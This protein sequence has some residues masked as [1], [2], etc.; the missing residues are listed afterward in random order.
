MANSMIP[1]FTRKSLVEWAGEQVV[2][3]AERMVERGLVLSAEYDPPVVRGTVLANNQELTTSLKLHHDGTVE[4]L[5][6]CYANRERGIVCSHVIAIASMLVRRRTDPM[7]EAKYQEEQRRAKRLASIP[8]TEYLQRVPMFTAGACPASVKLTLPADWMRQ[9]RAGRV[10][11]GCDVVYHEKAVPISDAPRNLSY[12]FER[13]DEALLFVLED[14]AEGP[15]P[16]RIAC[17]PADFLNLVRLRRGGQLYWDQHEP[18]QVNNVEMKSVVRID[19]DR[20]TGELILIAHTELPF[21]RP[22]EFPF[23]LVAGREAWVYGAGN[24]WALANRLPPAYEA[25]YVEPIV[26]P[27]EGVIPFFRQEFSRFEGVIALETELSD[28]LFTVDMETPHFCLKVQGS[29]ASLSSTLFARYRNV[30]L[31]AGKPDAKGHFAFPDPDDL[32]RYT[33]R[34]EAAETDA[35]AVLARMGLKAVAGDGI[36]P[37]V[38]RRD[39]LN[40]MAGR[41]PMLRR[42]GW[43]IEIEGKAAVCLETADF[44]TPVV[45]LADAP[46][47]GWFDVG[48]TYEDA[49][50]ATVSASDIQVALQ[51][52]EYFIEKSGRTLFID[53]NAIS[54]LHDVFSDCGTT[55]GDAAGS[56][57]L[58]DI[59]AP[60]VRTSLDALDG[61]DVD[62]S[63]SWRAMTKRFDKPLQAEPTNL[64]AAVASI[65]RPYQK[66]GVNWLH[67]LSQ[68][69]FAG[70]LADEM[71]L[72]KTLQALVWI[73]TIVDKNSQAHHPV[74]VVCPTSLVENWQE[75]ALR[76][77]PSLKVLPLS[78][79]E[80]HDHWDTMDKYDML[81]TSYAL[82]RRDVERYSS[83]EFL[84]MILDEAQHIKNRST[85]N[86]TAA[87]QIRARH[88]LVLTGTPLENS[89]SDLWSIMDFLM[90]G[91]LGS[92]DSFRQNYDMPITRGGPDAEPAQTKLRRKIGPFLLRRRK[93]DVARDLP[94]KLEKTSW[95]QLSPDQKM[96]Y[97]TILN[98]SRTKLQDM[99]RQKSFN[100]C[101]MEVLT[102]LMRLRQTCCHLDLLKLPDLK[103]AAPS[104]KT[105]LFLELV[106]EAVDSGHRMLVFS[107]FVG[108]LT[109]LRNQLERDGIRY[110][111]L[112]GS[113]KDRLRI[114]HEFNSD[115]TIPLFLISLKAGGVGLNLT[116][117][118]MVIHFD[119]WWNP[120][121][122]DQATD[123][124][125]RIGQK[126]TVYSIKLITRNTIEEKVLALQERKRRVIAAT[127]ES[128]DN[129]MQQLTWEDVQEL[130]EL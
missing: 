129:V 23:H 47:A 92:H 55:D 93:L 126:R 91:Y 6:P 77:M 68:N 56:F 86:A 105:E 98:Q 97:A 62:D 43:K 37:V 99:V 71:G 26:V 95:C 84:A 28:D 125:H 19:L 87:K 73:R 39:V 44:V 67:F 34:N 106:D 100:R 114:V 117:A 81:I 46:G 88:R 30:E 20:E 1:G 14:I 42:M 69:G 63:P 38:G 57:R 109:I 130:L 76:F 45:H 50:G 80:R 13:T 110:C 10:E 52:N 21:V 11:V 118:D 3:E 8:D 116:G 115:K 94:P 15:I 108:M 122:E 9:Y 5:C 65:L 119:P 59:Y 127:I 124:A 75:E 17:K 31:V 16:A 104:A 96:V 22:G 60:F 12:S 27:R 111:Y 41:I 2:Q 113:T 103:A 79:T 4:S 123:R 89:V 53:G 83:S 102:A 66:D 24:F 64:P 61:V 74:L 107:Q 90:P 85:K 72:G 36:P 33:V 54:A 48:F 49:T 35:L 7:R 101:R 78:G 29:L 51:K 70:I 58:K 32:M 40:F 120:A 82:L 128:D 121:A 18:V 112:D 25:L